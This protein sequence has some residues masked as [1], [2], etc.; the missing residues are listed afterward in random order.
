M[1]IARTITNVHPVERW[2]SVLGGGAL[3]I[4]GLSKG[5][6]GIGRTLT[7][8]A[9]LKRGISGHCDAYR[10]LGIRTAP[11]AATIPYELGVRARAAV[12][13]AAPRDK[14][15]QFWQQLE[16]LPRFMTH[17]ISVQSLGNK[18]SHWVAKGPAGREV[19]WDAETINEIENEL[20]AWKS[21]PGSDV[22]SAG[23]VRFK[24][25]P[26][27]RG[28]EIRVELQYDP[29]GGLLGAYVA[30]LFGREPEQEIN[31]DLIRLKQFLESGE[32]ATI[33]GQPKGGAIHK[34][35]VSVASRMEAI[36]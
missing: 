14:V 5:R 18:R 16:N 27:G 21:L 24:D 8:A 7:G 36:A 26:G 20:I 12:T 30:H 3:A 15:F 19:A 32:F 34:S 6:S 23:S 17:L 4:S 2:L 11:S 29:P 1:Q 35:K 25:A 33:E 9:L 10:L 31:A 22:A 13:V 28:T